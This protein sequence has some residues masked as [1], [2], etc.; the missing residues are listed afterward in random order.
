MIVASLYITIDHQVRITR[1]G[2]RY[3]KRQTVKLFQNN[4]SILITTAARKCASH[5]LR[6]VF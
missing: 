1:Y 5:F 4:E 3:A 2:R 6:A